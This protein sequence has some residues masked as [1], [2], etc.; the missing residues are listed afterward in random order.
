M[1]DYNA[2]FFGLYENLFIT[3][4]QELGEEEA[5]ELFRKV[6]ER[7]LKKAYDAAGFEKGSSRE[8]ARVVGERDESVG[9]KIS[10]PVV[11]ENN[12][13]YRF[14]TDPFPNLKG[15]VGAEELDD[16]YMRFK[17]GYLLGSEWGY[18]TTTHLWRGGEFTEHIIYRKKY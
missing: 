13:V 11:E 1:K 9:L 18:E 7:G 15:V 8:F 12:I 3:L 5:L 14:H 4:K 6:M 16:K 17:V 10:F 2:A